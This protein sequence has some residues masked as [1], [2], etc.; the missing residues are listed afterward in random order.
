MFSSSFV[1]IQSI[2]MYVIKTV[3]T[4]FYFILLQVLF[5]LFIYF[6]LWRAL[7][8]VQNLHSM[9]VLNYYQRLLLISACLP[10]ILFLFLKKSY[11]SPMTKLKHHLFYNLT[12]QNLQTTFYY[13]PSTPVSVRITFLPHI[14]KQNKTNVLKFY[15]VLI[16]SCLENE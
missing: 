3:M 12:Q 5:Y 15:F 8:I 9:H 7:D 14:S 11:L 4:S 16:E 10:F 1:P 13:L 2:S 6:Y